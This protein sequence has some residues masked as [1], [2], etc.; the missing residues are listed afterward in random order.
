MSTNNS[1]LVE[2]KQALINAHN[3]NNA[4]AISKDFAAGS[5]VSEKAFT[6][7]TTWIDELHAK[8]LPW[9]E[10]WNN[11]KVSDEEIQAT[12][13]DIMP[14]LR[15]IQRVDDKLFIRT[16]DIGAI[17]KMCH[18]FGKSLNGTVDVANGKRAFRRQIEAMVGNRIAQNEVLSEDDYGIIVKYDRAVKNRDKAELRLEGYTDAKGAKVKGLKEQLEEATK[19]YND[20][21]KIAGITPEIEAELKK[22]KKNLFDEYPI[23]AGYMATVV[24]LENTIKSTE[25]N[26]DNAKETIKKL[27]KDYKKLM[28]KIKEV[29]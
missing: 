26:I 18:E 25:G 24:N 17:C 21:K 3:A 23:V 8:V 29:K 4:K 13:D 15:Q 22:A 20:M 14:I 10:K 19:V 5:G 6:S 27:E 2:M 1:I 11:G 12:Y 16:N 9:V 28:A 7:W